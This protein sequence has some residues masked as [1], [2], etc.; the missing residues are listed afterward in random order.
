MATKKPLPAASPLMVC[1]F[2]GEHILIHTIK[3]K[4]GMDRFFASGKLDYGCGWQTGLFQDKQQLL[5]AISWRDGVPPKFK[6]APITAVPKVPP[7]DEMEAKSIAAAATLAGNKA[8][9]MV[10]AA[11]EIK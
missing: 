9:E 7:A 10:K 3:N 11:R 4:D 6:R 1:P 5:V 2:T 8:A